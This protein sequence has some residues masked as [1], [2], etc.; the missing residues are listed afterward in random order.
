MRLGVPRR[1]KRHWKP[2]EEI[3]PASRAQAPLSTRISVDLPAPFS[4]RRTW[5]SP[6]SSSKSTA[7]S[8]VT[9]GNRLLMPRICSSGGEEA[10]IVNWVKE[11]S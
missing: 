11:R 9:P 5:T 10:I 8:A 2:V 6:R 4:P 7:S 1:T 3:S